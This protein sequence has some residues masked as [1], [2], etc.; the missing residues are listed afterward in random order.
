MMNRSLYAVL[1]AGS[2]L[3]L[4]ACGGLDAGLDRG[5]AINPLSR[6]VLQV[7]P[8]FDRIALRARSDG[9]SEPQRRAVSQLATRYRASAQTGLVI[10]VPGAGDNVTNATA[11]NIVNALAGYGIGSSQISMGSYEAPGADAP[12]LVGF[13]TIRA[14]VP[15]C[16]TAWGSAT[17]TAQNTGSANFGCAVTANLA[18]Q[19]A[20]PNDIVS[21]QQMTPASAQRRAVVYDA[22]RQ[23]TPTSA[24]REPLL[25]EARISDVV[26]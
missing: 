10:Q 7:E 11:R 20:N 24:T 6:Y 9:L 14:Q 1:I 25:V 23:G 5:P 12:V 16:G 19:I 21:P 26:E 3:G 13:E 18:A 8:D 2:A 15:Q 22:Y 17:R 4:A